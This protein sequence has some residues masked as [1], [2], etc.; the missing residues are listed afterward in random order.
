MPL[1]ARLLSAAK[2]TERVVVGLISG[3]SVDAIEA[4]ACRIRGT[5]EKSRLD[6]LSHVSVHF[7]PALA[8][9]IFALS[10]VRELCALNF[11]L[12]ERFGKAALQAIA[13]A[14]LKPADVDLVGSHGQT[15]AHLPGSTL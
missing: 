14:R 11:E 9:R 7:P 1:P 15:V 8:K 10:T 12:G 4:V 6:L 5:G 3:T 2:K 13:V